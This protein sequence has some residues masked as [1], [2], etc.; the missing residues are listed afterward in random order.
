MIGSNI[1]DA[2]LANKI[3]VFDWDG[4]PIKI[5]NLDTEVSNITIDENDRVIYAYSNEMEQLIKFKLE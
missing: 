1:Y 2:Y 5:L 4:N 3:I